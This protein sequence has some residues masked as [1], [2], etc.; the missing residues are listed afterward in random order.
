M[1]RIIMKLE[2]Y[3][4]ELSAEHNAAMAK[5]VQLAEQVDVNDCNIQRII[6]ALD[7]VTKAQAVVNELR[8]ADAEGGGMDA[9]K[10]LLIAG[11]TEAVG[12]AADA[13][14]VI[15]QVQA[16]M[17]SVQKTTGGTT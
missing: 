7:G 3:K 10:G 16:S 6:G 15:R 14:K 8:Q 2:V 4:Q 9:K 12:K 13:V 17:E 1:E 11:L 5:K